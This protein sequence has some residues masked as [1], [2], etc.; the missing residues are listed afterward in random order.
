MQSNLFNP[1][2]KQQ[3]ESSKCRKDSGISEGGIVVCGIEPREF[4]LVGVANEKQTG[5]IT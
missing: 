5:K 2:T 4:L 3:N 1:K